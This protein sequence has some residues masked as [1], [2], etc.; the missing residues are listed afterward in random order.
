MDLP[1]NGAERP[2]SSAHVPPFALASAQ[3]AEQ[4]VGHY[5]I[6]M[7]VKQWH[8]GSLVDL[9][10]QMQL[11]TFLS[12]RH[13][14]SLMDLRWRGGFSGSGCIVSS[15]H[16]FAVLAAWAMIFPWCNPYLRTD[17]T[18]KSGERAISAKRKRQLALLS[19]YDEL[20]DEEMVRSPAPRLDLPLPG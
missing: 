15:S 18:G 17:E 10:L 16:S 5:L 7:P 2:A 6:S 19:E 8:M 12:H 1:A 13:C 11:K 4:E 20:A 3:I 9:A 14:Q